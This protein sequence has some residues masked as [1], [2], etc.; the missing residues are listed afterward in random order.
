MT[1]TTKQGEYRR[2]TPQEIGQAVTT[3]RKVIGMKQLTLALEAGVNER[4]VQRIERGEKVDD[5]T[6][7][8]IAKALRM[9]E[10]AF[11]GM[12]YVPTPEEA[13][14]EAEKMLSQVLMI[15]A[16]EFRTVKDC[17]ALLNAMG[18]FVDDRHV[19]A[20]LAHEIAAL[21]DLILDWGD[22]YKEIPHINQAEACESVLQQAQKIANAGYIMRYGV[23]TTEDNFR[24]SALVF[25]SKQDDRSAQVKQLLVPRRFTE[26]A[27]ATLRG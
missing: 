3:F 19:V 9:Q 26:L 5:E 8:K 14:A 6:L 4:T 17:D 24:V 16:S 18:Y 15:E 27:L 22:I 10:D 20:E 1:E 7:R 12:R 23:Y 13:V 2:L 11:I 25:L 21:K